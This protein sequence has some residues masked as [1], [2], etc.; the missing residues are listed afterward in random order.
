MARRKSKSGCSGC[1]GLLIVLLA[2]TWFLT[3]GERRND[4]PASSPGP[5]TSGSSGTEN[6]APLTRPGQRYVRYADSNGNLHVRPSTVQEDNEAEQRQ[7]EVE[8]LLRD[9]AEKS[10]STSSQPQTSGSVHVRGYYR[11][12]GTYVRPHTRR[13]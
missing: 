1:L 5:A 10:P 4:E 6:L 12:D 8:T 13:R 7:R 11:K 2:A 3:R 9:G